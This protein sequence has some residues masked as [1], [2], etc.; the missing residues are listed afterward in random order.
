METINIARGSCSLLLKKIP[1]R[2]FQVAFSKAIFGFE[3]L[4]VDRIQQCLH[5]DLFIELFET[6]KLYFFYFE[7]RR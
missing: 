2:H 3:T 4:H 5:L 6:L 7:S 1:K